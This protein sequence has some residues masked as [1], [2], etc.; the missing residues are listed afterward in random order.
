MDN[1]SKLVQSPIR[2]ESSSLRNLLL[3]WSVFKSDIGNLLEPIDIDCEPKHDHLGIEFLNL[4]VSDLLAL[5]KFRLILADTPAVK[6]SLDE[7]LN[8]LIKVVYHEELLAQLQLVD[9]H[10][11]GIVVDHSAFLLLRPPVLQHLGFDAFDGLDLTSL[12]LSLLCLVLFFIDR[13]DQVFKLMP[14]FMSHVSLELFGEVISI[15]RA[16]ICLREV[17]TVHKVLALIILAV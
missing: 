5:H 13:R 1:L 12:L 9:V 16:F 6:E 17:Q 15:Q 2:L 3:H 7:L 8:S 4:H 11:I 10:R 14:L